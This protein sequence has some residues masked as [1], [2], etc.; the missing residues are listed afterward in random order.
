MTLDDRHA[1]LRAG[2]DTF[3]AD[4]LELE[5]LWFGDYL[6]LWRP[7]TSPSGLIRP[8]S[9]GPEVLWLRKRLG[10]TL[11]A[12]EGD[13]YDAALG[14]SIAKFQQAHH[15]AADGLAG[16]RTQ[17]VLDGLYVSAEGP[18]LLAERP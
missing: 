13:Y 7:P 8:G 17:R 15:L 3:D 18:H 12:N 4:L 2:A 9:R 6:I 1:R 16:T 5:P 10:E 11:P 14:R